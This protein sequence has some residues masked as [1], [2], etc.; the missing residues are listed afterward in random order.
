[1]GLLINK[2]DFESSGKYAIGTTNEDAVDAYIL[3]YEEKV[4]IE[5]LG[6]TL[7]DLFK[8]DVEANTVST[9]DPIYQ[10]IYDPIRIDDDGCIKFSYGMK[11]MVLGMV[12]FEIVRD[13]AVKPTSGGM[14]NNVSEISQ[15]ADLNYVYSRYN[16]S[17]NDQNVIQW[18]I[19]NHLTDYP[20][21]NFL[22]CF[23]KIILR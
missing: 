18:Y 5:L 16:E 13:L 20:T 3:R 19:E 21:Y 23:L 14:M 8:A 12:Y 2:S 11:S 6:V 22:F 4:I 9:L 17:I 15:F 1:V 7:F 10:V